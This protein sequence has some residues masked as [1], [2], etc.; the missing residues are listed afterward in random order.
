M[1]Y[2]FHVSLDSGL[3]QM[4]Q[5]FL[6]HIILIVVPIG[7]GFHNLILV[8]IVNIINTQCSIEYEHIQFGQYFSTRS[9]NQVVVDV[10]WNIYRLME[11]FF[12]DGSIICKFV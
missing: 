1:N 6:L 12:Y 8:R 7:G 9:R 10:H 2:Y 5:M 11:L 3:N 4:A